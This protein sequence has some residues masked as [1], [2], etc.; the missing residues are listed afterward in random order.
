[1]TPTASAPANKKRPASRRATKPRVIT[2]KSSA[3][4]VDNDSLS[5]VLALAEAKGLLSG[6][7]T[8]VIRGRMT[9]ELVAEAKRRT[10][11]TS[12]SKLIEAALAN[13]A[14]ADDYWEWMITQRGTVSR[15]LDLDF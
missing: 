10:G 12:D 2:V 5:E 14:V 6:N 4:S 1:M 15:D 8:V 13:I 3:D 7:R 9:E 11:I